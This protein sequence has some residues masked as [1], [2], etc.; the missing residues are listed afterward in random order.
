MNKEQEVDRASAARQLAMRLTLLV[1]NIL[2]AISPSLRVN[3]ILSAIC[4]FYLLSVLPLV[5]VV[6]G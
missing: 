1:N 6:K 4:P 2:S 3:N 5:A